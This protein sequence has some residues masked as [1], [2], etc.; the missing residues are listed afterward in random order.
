ML[1]MFLSH[2]ITSMS[3][4]FAGGKLFLAAADDGATDSPIYVLDGNQFTQH[5]EIK[6]RYLLAVCPFT[7]NRDTFLFAQ[8]YKSD[9]Y[10]DAA[11][12]YI[13]KGYMYKWT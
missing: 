7:R 8:D 12:E 2:L 13:G 11:R 6:G 1:N 10:N 5:V 3:F 9:I 4:L